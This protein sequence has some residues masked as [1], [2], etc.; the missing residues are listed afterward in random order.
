MVTSRRRPRPTGSWQERTG[1]AVDVDGAGAALRDAAAVLGAGQPEL[2]A[3][4]PEQR[5]VGVG[6]DLVGG[7]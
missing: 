2:V 3:Q 4:H 6:V 1:C 7:R 5:R